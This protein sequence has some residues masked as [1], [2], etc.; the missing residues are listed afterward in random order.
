MGKQQLAPLDIMH[1]MSAA[2]VLA[3]DAPSASRAR[4]FLEGTAA[5]A[6]WMALA[7][8]LHLSA[9]G[10]LLFGNSHHSRFSAMRT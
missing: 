9:Y 5:V 7:L 1:P 4:R 3:C 8:T 6:L 2:S 10:Y